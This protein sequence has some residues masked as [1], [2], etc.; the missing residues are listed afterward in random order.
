MKLFE[1]VNDYSADFT[2]YPRTYESYRWYKPIIIAVLAFIIYIILFS[3]VTYT[4]VRLNII[5]RADLLKAF[6]SDAVS[7]ERIDGIITSLSV[8][9][10]IPAIYIP[11]RLVRQKPVWSIGGWKWDVFLKS[12]GLSLAVYAVIS[13]IFILITGGK[14]NNQFTALTLILCLVLTPFQ[15]IAEEYLCRGFL[16]Q[17]FG[18]WFKVPVIAIILQ[19]V[20]FCLLHEYNAIGLAS[21]LISGLIFGWVSWKTK[22]IEVSSA[23]HSANNIIT[24][25][26]FGF[27]LSAATSQIL[28]TDL[29]QS[30]L[31]EIIS[32]AVIFYIEKKY[33][34]IGLK[35]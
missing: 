22:G 14:F 7:M 19:A 27:G 3:A 20:I 8:I 24:F 2:T 17:A 28:M 5:P 13:A 31:T 34:W 4:A 33:G 12:A 15:C 29:I 18:S 11:S 16:M 1:K 10:L 9:L 35:N 6:T 21:V 23:L 32:I 25:L 30:L 26:I